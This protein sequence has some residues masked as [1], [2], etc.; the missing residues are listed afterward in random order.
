MA[1][2]P[3]YAASPKTGIVNI[4]TA[5]TNRDGTGTIG[6]VM[7]GG[8]SGSRV[9]T[10]RVV[11]RGTTTAGMIRLYRYNGTTSFLLK[12]IPVAA[13]TPSATVPAFNALV[14]FLDD[15]PCYLPSSSWKLQASTEKGESFNVFADGAD[16]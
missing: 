12:E 1:L 16:L 10:V 3:Q 2:D 13:V 7:T 11:A 15:D 6:D 8:A 9:D 4:S 5:N 14:R